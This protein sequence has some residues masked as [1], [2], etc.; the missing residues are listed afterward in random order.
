[1]V[2]RHLQLMYTNYCVDC[3]AMAGALIV[4]LDGPRDILESVTI[5]DGCPA[6][7]YR[8]YACDAT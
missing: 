6:G 8:W 4:D 1:M 3:N 2:V 5:C 7:I